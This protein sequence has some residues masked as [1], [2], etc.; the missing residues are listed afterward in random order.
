MRCALCL[1]NSSHPFGITFDDN[2]ICSG[3]KVHFEKDT[4]DWAFKRSRLESLLDN[5]RS[6]I[7]NYDCIVPITGGQD[8]FFIVH[9]VR[10][11]LKLN[12]L[13]VN[14]NRSFNSKI[15]LANLAK[16]RTSFDVD[17]RQFT[18]DPKVAKKVIRNTIAN[19]G[20][21]NWLNIAGQTSFPVRVA[22]E[23]KIPLIIWGAHQGVEQVGMYSH[24]DEVEMTSRYRTE[25]D[26]LGIDENDILESAPD[27]TDD[28]I[29]SLRY[30][31]D[32]ELDQIGV[33]GIYLSNFFRWDPVAQ[34][35]L[36]KRVYGYIGKES[37]STYYQFDNPDCMIY[38]SYQD[39]LKR[40]KLGYGKVTD[41]L[42]RDIRH[43][44]ISLSK[45]KKIESKYSSRV[46]HSELAPFAD[47]LEVSINALKLS[48]SNQEFLR[49]HRD[50]QFIHARE[51]T[52]K[53][54]GLASRLNKKPSTKDVDFSNYGKGYTS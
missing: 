44:R 1:Y 30:P 38:N 13:V 7:G 35:D 40:A 17:F 19:L 54:I 31:S 42:V 46:E 45:A 47:W 23:K 5:Y 25:H 29:S 3:C 18:I 11:V 37:V 50:S 21:A 43:K 8:S 9:L 51:R 52:S 53:G 41:Q 32:F 15:G 28:D 6:Q 34:H 27:F 10:N 20:T 36:V 33:R 14:F 12:P 49:H 24:Y 4:I 16:L 22:V 26:L 48:I 39:L 2:G